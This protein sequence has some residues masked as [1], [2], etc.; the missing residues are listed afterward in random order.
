[1][2]QPYVG[3]IRMFAGNFAPA[4]WAL[5]NGQLMAIADNP[6]LF[7]LIGT[8]YGGD[9][10]STFQLPDLRGRLPVHQGAGPGLSSYT[11]ADSAGVESVTLTAAQMP[12][13]THTARAR[14]GAGTSDVPA[15]RVWAAPSEPSAR[16][17]AGGAADL[18]MNPALIQ[19]AGGGQPHDNVAPFQAIYFIISLLGIFPSQV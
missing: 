1:M 17:Y 13:H 10:M 7:Q 4:G 6:T 3:E 5:C 2:S 8:T 16:L 14:A 12:S 19:P 9:G 11:L 15:N 18:S